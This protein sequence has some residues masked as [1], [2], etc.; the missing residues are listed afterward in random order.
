MKNNK[1]GKNQ[2]TTQ[3]VKATQNKAAKKLL[4]EAKTKKNKIKT[5]LFNLDKSAKGTVSPVE[6]SKKKQ[7]ETAFALASSQES[8]AQ[9]EQQAD[10]SQKNILDKAVQFFSKAKVAEAENEERDKTIKKYKDK[11]AAY[12]LETEETNNNKIHE[13]LASRLLAPKKQVSVREDSEGKGK[14]I[15]TSV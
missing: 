6:V 10:K 15:S 11:Y 3:N 14:Y 7:L 4:A 2:K 12:Q 5:T 13:R 1:I 9:Q 8:K